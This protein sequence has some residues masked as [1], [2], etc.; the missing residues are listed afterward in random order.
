MKTENNKIIAEFMRWKIFNDELLDHKNLFI[1]YFDEPLKFHS[2]WNW[3]ME[4]VEK[5][6]KT[7]EDENIED[8]ATCKELLQVI[9]EAF[10]APQK[11]NVYN[12]C[13]DFINWYNEQKN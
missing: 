3:L 1:Q 6:F 11:E 9:K 8:E 10:Y 5:I 13:L 2:D 4:L 12:C 7:A